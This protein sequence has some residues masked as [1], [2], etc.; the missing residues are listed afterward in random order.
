[1]N[2]FFLFPCVCVGGGGSAASFCYYRK[3]TSILPH[4]SSSVWCLYKCFAARALSV[5]SAIRKVGWIMW[6]A[7]YFQQACYS[8]S[9]FF[10]SASVTCSR[11]AGG[12]HH[13]EVDQLSSHFP[14]GTGWQGQSRGCK[15]PEEQGRGELM[16]G[17]H[18][19]AWKAKH[20]LLVWA[21]ILRH[22]FMVFTQ[23]TRVIR[24][25]VSSADNTA[26]RHRHPLLP[27]LKTR[28]SLWS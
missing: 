24:T 20:V 25:A 8:S 9:E 15:K 3:L 27:S 7:F 10:M 2:P 16:W 13:K 17:I 18:C 4:E 19:D 6:H 22:L 1:M 12:F 28:D 5:P 11:S 21:W 26:Y 23:F 14:S